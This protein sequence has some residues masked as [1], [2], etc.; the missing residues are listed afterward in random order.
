MAITIAN[1]LKRDHLLNTAMRAFKKRLLPLK[2]LS[3]EFL[4]VPLEG[5][6]KVQVPYFPLASGASTDWVAGTGYVIG[7][8]QGLLSKEVTVNKRKFRGVQFT[9]DEF[10]R[11]PFLKQEEFLAL[12]GE[13][14]AEDVIAD[15][16][17]VV[18]AAN[19]TATT[20]TA[21]A[22]TAFDLDDVLALRELAQKLHWPS[23]V[24]SLVLDTAP[25]MALMK[26]S[27]L[28]YANAQSLNQVRDG[29]PDFDVAG[30][31][32]HE[33]PNLPDNGAEK[34]IGAA[35]YSS[36]ILVAA[37]PINPTNEVRKIIDYKRVTDADTGLTFEYRAWGDPDLDLTKEVIEVSY[38]Y[39]V[40]EVNALLRITKP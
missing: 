12:E 16:W 18:T 20:L 37:A 27:R 31:K 23:A 33:V 11:Q 32:P 1:A 4:D 3:T 9:S 24:R 39:A 14:L 38:G 2:A 15:I 7:Q 10:T 17:S 5:T 25:G 26:D 8:N 21:Q 30:F 36:A 28:G 34:L 6:N 22:A 19:F 29:F 35:I 13:K 40:G